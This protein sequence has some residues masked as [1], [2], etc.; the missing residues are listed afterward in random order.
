MAT[1][2]AM[3]LLQDLATAGQAYKTG[4]SGARRKLLHLC[5]EL[6]LELEPPGETFLRINWAEVCRL[7]FFSPAEP[8][9]LTIQQTVRAIAIR[10]A[11]D[12]DIYKTL[13]EDE[14]SPKSSAQ[15]AA[16]KSA[17]PLL[18]GMARPAHSQLKHMLL[19]GPTYFSKSDASLGSNVECSRGR[20]GSIRAHQVLSRAGQLPN[21]RCRRIRVR[22]CGSRYDPSLDDMCTDNPTDTTITG[23]FGG[24]P[25]SGLQSET[26]NTPRTHV[27]QLRPKPGV[28]L[29]LRSLNIM[30]SIPTRVKSSEP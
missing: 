26:G 13:S 2:T 21:E 3:G 25:Q 24:T 4:D 15:L 14:G 27:I 9:R 1:D 5:N 7:R 10:I 30:L 16:P 28:F 20:Q 12:L 23:T 18:V 22:T 8:S 11:I 17:D 6:T 29:I 19:T